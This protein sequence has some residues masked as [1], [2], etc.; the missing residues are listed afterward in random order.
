MTATMGSTTT[1]ALGGV[2]RRK[3][4]P[5]LIQGRGTYT[6]DIKFKGE[7]AAAFTRSPFAHARIT[8]IDTSAAEAMPGV[9]AVYTIDDVRHLGTL[10]AQVPVGAL[11]PLLADGMVKH[12]GE[13]VAMVVADDRYLAQDAADAV[14][15][16]YDPLDAI[17]DLK[18]ALSDAT[19][20][21]DSLESNVLISWVGPFGAEAD[22]Q[23]QV[24][25][26][27]DAAK[28][29]ED[30]VTV[31][32]EMV[33]Q[34]LI[35]VAIEPRAVVAEYNRGYGQLTV[36]D[37]TQIPHALAGA[38]G[39]TLGLLINQVRVV[40]PEVGGGFGCKLN[41]YN[42]EVLVSW[43]AMQLDRPVRW[44]ETRREAANSTIQTSTD[45]VMRGR[46]MALYM[47]VFLGATPIGSPIIGWIGETFGAR[48]T[49][50]GG[51]LISVLG[52]AEFLPD[53]F[54]WQTPARDMVLRYIGTGGLSY[55]EATFG[56][57]RVSILIHPRRMTTWDG[58]GFDRTFHRESVWHEMAEAP[59]QD[60]QG[61]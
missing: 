42:D 14:V 61:R 51:G 16:D 6:D 9:H 37:S 32:Q 19:K 1:S 59:G 54:D 25:A 48:W 34:R 20:V 28:E 46:V 38:L 31:S 5:A 44:T 7:L 45:P 43:A 18:D 27:I 33:N 10:I 41:V 53:T 29:R 50:L 4:D 26:D 11:R 49:L 13:A 17:I 36:Y 40:A 8:S 21:H 58:G 23:A 52:V 15:V 55:A 12:V 30:T 24:K 56:F 2:V 22:A 3:E 60:V 47:M 39:T 57:P 35:P